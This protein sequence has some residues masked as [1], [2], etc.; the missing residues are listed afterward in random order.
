MRTARIE[1]QSAS[2]DGSFILGKSILMPDLH[3]DNQNYLLLVFTG[4]TMK[5]VES[6]R[7]FHEKVEVRPPSWPRE[8]VPQHK[9]TCPI[10]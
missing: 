9:Y 3:D 7:T 5:V 2:G 6:M 10:F 4:I 1:L 8:K